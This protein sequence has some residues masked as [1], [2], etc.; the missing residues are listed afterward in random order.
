M[1]VELEVAIGQAAFGS[2]LVGSVSMVS[3][4]SSAMLSICM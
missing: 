1:G 2:S 4:A 3:G